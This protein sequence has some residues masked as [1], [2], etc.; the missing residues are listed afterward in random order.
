[1]PIGF[2][3]A[4]LPIGLQIVGRRFEE[5]AVLAAAASVER[6][7]PWAGAWPP[8]SVARPLPG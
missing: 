5:S 2:G 6:V 8:V 1:M 4:A 7:L 3:D